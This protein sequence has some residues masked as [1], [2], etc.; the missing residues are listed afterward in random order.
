MPYL[1]SSVLLVS[2]HVHEQAPPPPPAPPPAA[3]HKLKEKTVFFP[4]PPTS[5]LLVDG[6]QTG[7]GGASWEGTQWARSSR[8]THT[9]TH[10]SPGRRSVHQPAVTFDL[11]DGLLSLSGGGRGLPPLRRRRS[12]SLFFV[13]VVSSRLRSTLN[14]RLMN[15]VFIVQFLVSTSSHD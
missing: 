5:L 2:F 12:R 9:H 13:C 1:T 4:V 15:F 11:D 3:K 7:G 8:F 10:T 14:L 6:A